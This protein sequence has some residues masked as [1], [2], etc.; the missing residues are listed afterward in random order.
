MRRIVMGIAA[1]SSFALVGVA[2]SPA[3][4]ARS[5]VAP[6][7]PGASGARHVMDH[8][9]KNT[10]PPIYDSTVE[11]NPG[12][13]AS[14]SYEADSIAQFGNQ[15]SFAGTARVLDNVVVQMSS[16]ACQ[17]GSWSTP[18]G[19]ATPN[20]C[21]T[22]TPGATFNEPITLNIY[23]V[24][25]GNAYGPSTLGSLIA[26][27]T[28]TFAIAYRPSE[29]DVNCTTGGLPDGGWY[30]AALATCFNGSLTSVQ[31]NFGHVTLPNNVIYGI[32]YNTSDWGSTPYGDATACH[33]ATDS[34]VTP[35]TYDDCGYD[36][37]NVASSQEP[38]APSVGS[39]TY[40]GT[41]YMDVV[42][43]DYAVNEY[44]DDGAAGINV[45]RI[46]EP[47]NYPTGNGTTSGCW[48][49]NGNGTSPWY[50]PA[51]QFNAVDSAAA[52]I[53]SAN[54]ANVVAGTP[55]S[56]T[57]TTTGV[58]TPT[59]TEKGKLPSGLTFADNGN[60]TATISGTAPQKDRI[61]SY[62]LIL[63]AKNAEG[64]SSQ[65][66]SLT[67]TRGSIPAVSFVASTMFYPQ[68]STGFVR[69]SLTYPTSKTVTVEFT[70]SNGPPDGLDWGGWIGAAS[71][72]SPS[73]GTVTFAPGQT[74]ANIRF[75]VN[76]THVDGCGV[77]YDGLNACYPS[78]TVTLDNPTNAVLG[79]TPST[80]LFYEGPTPP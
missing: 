51:V 64:S 59:I 66:F 3:V 55:F 45:F 38:T 44:C 52:A 6:A 18:T 70:N 60:G 1:L 30:D 33:N 26:S 53:T 28:Q 42:A 35:A 21:L 34:Y 71:S 58:P 56:F 40:P 75:K 4:V 68:N 57:V 36:S 19:S 31:F 32:A 10:D 41:E 62:H 24:G 78:V 29:D 39:D 74:K 2:T 17:Q 13:L 12:N 76:P 22:P 9:S 65:S 63:K 8:K 49:V 14:M 37:L 69:L 43:E 54:S 27:D 61:K 7:S 25:P 80:N 16:W 72:F 50:I 15:I 20:P 23:D 77:Y 73:T 46:D 11:P 47:A 67:L 5:L 48:S 79:S